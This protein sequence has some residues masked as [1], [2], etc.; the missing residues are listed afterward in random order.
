M[1]SADHVQ[2]YPELLQV[3]LAHK[4]GMR[5]LVSLSPNFLS[6]RR[7]NLVWSCIAESRVSGFAGQDAQ[8]LYSIEVPSIRGCQSLKLLELLDRCSLRWWQG[9]R[10][11]WQGWQGLRRCGKRVDLVR[12]RLGRVGRGQLLIIVG[13]LELVKIQ[14]V[15]VIKN[16]VH[17]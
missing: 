13:A 4:A 1:L 7:E 14:H 15:N 3:P 5:L 16:L 8:V 6:C 2:S 9:F 11:R 12:L 10:Q 17:I